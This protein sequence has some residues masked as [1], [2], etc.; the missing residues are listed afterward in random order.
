VT[1]QDGSGNI[2]SDITAGNFSI[3]TGVPG[4]LSGSLTAA[5]VNVDLTAQGALDW[6]HWGLTSASSFDHRAGVTQ[7]IS[8]FSPIGGG[9]L[10]RQQVSP[11]SYSW[12]N[13]TPTA[14]ATN[15]PTGVYKVGTG[16]GFEVTV[17][18]D[19]TSRTL[20][21]YIGLWDAQGKLEATLS[22]GS[23]AS[24]VDTTLINQTATSNGLYTLTYQAGSAGQT[25]RIRWTVQ[26]S[27]NSFG[28]VTL[29]AAALTA[30]FAN[31]APT[32]NAGT[33][34][35]ITLPNT[36][37]LSGT[38]SDD[39]LPNP[40]GTL[41]TTWSKV[42]GPGT[43]TFGNPNALSTTVSF[44]AAGTYTL[45]LTANDSGLTATDDVVVT[46]NST[47]Q[48]PT[49]NA[50]TDQTITLPNTAALSGTASDDGLPKSSRN[51][52]HHLVQGERPG[53]RH[54]RESE[55]P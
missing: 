21:L 1:S 52:D 20:K 49:V 24:Y 54:F 46:V 55:C 32:V 5:P 8:N 6:A 36:A 33:D 42:S 31:Q 25:L 29:Q 35:T 41:T 45:R 17:P 22:D 9:T 39:G 44:S 18:A 23:A 13:G 16:S 10:S 19:T 50:G 4:Q 27:F 15:T 12:S 11:T 14:S 37:A 51:P 7:Q 30:P 26:A 3:V 43:V 53:H 47:N 34:Q 2:G 48:A 38:A 40:P 28:N